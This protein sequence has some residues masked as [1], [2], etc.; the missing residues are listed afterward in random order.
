MNIKFALILS[1]SVLLFIFFLKNYS[2]K[3]KQKKL[4]PNINYLS[5]REEKA[6]RLNKVN[7]IIET[8]KNIIESNKTE[9]KST[10]DYGQLDSQEL[11]KKISL[12]EDKI[13][14]NNYMKKANN[15]DL[16]N[17]EYGEFRRLL[18]KRDKLYS[19]VL[20]KILLEQI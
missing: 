9:N 15:G 7:N 16:S 5:K 6:P 2:D 20:T 3:P 11:E 13:K 18:Q 4:S 17:V 8:D 1:G 12:I 19:L 10:N 14:F